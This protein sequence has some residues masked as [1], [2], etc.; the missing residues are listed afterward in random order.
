MFIHNL[1]NLNDFGLYS[2]LKKYIL[3]EE[4]GY[5]VNQNKFRELFDFVNVKNSR[6]FEKAFNDAIFLAIQLRN[7]MGNVRVVDLKRIDFMNEEQIKKLLFTIG[8]ARNHVNIAESKKIVQ[9]VTE[10]FGIELE[11]LLLCTVAGESMIGDNIFE[12]D[13]LII[14]TKTIPENGD[15]IVIT[16]NN[17]TVVK[18]LNLDGN[19]M[20]L[21]SA[22]N[23]FDPHQITEH[24]DYSI[25]GK[26]KHVI[27]SI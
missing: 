27:H 12:G 15:I 18:R 3:R 8:A 20:K 23:N 17:E 25:I 6:I 2:M 7:N 10:I 1:E 16:I 19:S 4:L 11:N 13:T 22:N 5:F 24:D 9:S 26:V 21:V 14:D